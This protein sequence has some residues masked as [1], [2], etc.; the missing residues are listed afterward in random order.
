MITFSGCPGG[1]AN[2]T[3]PNWV[4]APWPPEYLEI[5]RVAVEGRSSRTGRRRRSSPS[6][7][8]SRVAIEMHPGFVVYNPDTMLRLRDACGDSLGCNF[9][10]S[11]FFWQGIDPVVAV[12]ALGDCIFH[13]HAKDTRIDPCNAARQRR[14]R[15]QAATTD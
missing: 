2:A 11:H 6:R 3:K 12:R 1:D 13:V 15:H 4:T 14:A 10:P 8:A 9:D 7:P 5:A